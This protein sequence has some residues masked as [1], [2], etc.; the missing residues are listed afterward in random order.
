MMESFR[1]QPELALPA[2]HKATQDKQGL[3]GIR[4]MAFEAIMPY[5]FIMPAKPLGTPSS[6]SGYI[7]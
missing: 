1:T 7:I 6:S 5:P 3:P 4:M 2:S